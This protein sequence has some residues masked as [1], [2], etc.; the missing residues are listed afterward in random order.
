MRHSPC[1]HV[2]YFSPED[3][4]FVCSPQPQA[5]NVLLKSHPDDPRGFTAKV[6]DFGL[7]VQMNTAETHVSGLFQ[8]W[9]AKS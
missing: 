4:I 1:W 9:V 6:A 2:I 5:E 7:S 8:V 3:S